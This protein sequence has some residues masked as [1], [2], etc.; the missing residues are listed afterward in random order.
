[1]IQ[2]CTC[3]Q[4]GHTFPVHESFAGRML[5]C[6]KCQSLTP[7]P[8]PRARRSRGLWLGMGITVGALVMCCCCVILTT[9]TLLP[10]YSM[11]SDAERQAVYMAHRA[12]SSYGI[13]DSISMRAKSTV[14][15]DD[16]LVTHRV[17]GLLLSGR[18][19]KPYEIDFQV[20]GSEQGNVWRVRRVTLD[21]HT[22]VNDRGDSPRELPEVQPSAVPY[23]MPPT[24]Y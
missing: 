6:L 5:T 9:T 13:G 7:A 16:P 8:F 20:V 3:S 11:P 4:C 1:M 18:E 19:E 2:N 17:S 12:F 22:F 10:T 15:G 14:I 21:G 23:L 24:R